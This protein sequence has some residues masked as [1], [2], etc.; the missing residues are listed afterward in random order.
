MHWGRISTG[1]AAMV[2]SAWV[3]G[4]GW[5][6]G[7]PYEALIAFF[8]ALCAWG[9]F[10]YSSRIRPG[11]T[12]N[13]LR[14]SRELRNA[15]P[16]D[17]RIFL[18]AHDFG[19]PFGKNLLETIED[20]DYEW[21]NVTKEFDD[22]VLNQCARR[23][24]DTIGDFLPYLAKSVEL[25]DRGELSVPTKSE[26]ASDIFTDRTYASIRQL[27]DYSSSIMKY[28]DAFERKLRQVAPGEFG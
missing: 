2:T 3:G 17:V 5:T 1:L 7:P 9:K 8:T 18:N 23:I 28:L 14:L 26:R 21:R 15:F 4:S 25:S 24:V 20:L 10:E 16:L 19:A 13:D 11:I 12:P 6:N 22:S 27:S